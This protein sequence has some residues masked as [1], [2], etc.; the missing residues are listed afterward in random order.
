MISRQRKLLNEII[1]IDWI[2]E[3]RYYCKSHFLLFVFLYFKIKISLVFFTV[4]IAWLAAHAK[5]F[6]KYFYCPILSDKDN[7]YF[8]IKLPLFSISN[9][10]LLFC[11]S[12]RK[13]VSF[14]ACFL[15]KVLSLLIEFY[16]FI[17]F[18]FTWC[19]GTFCSLFLVLKLA[20]I[21]T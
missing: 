16:Y 5:L 10:C 4:F 18:C 21:K 2:K 3:K 8:E 14:S 12:T 7:F 9:V 15:S 19:S 11:F 1:V 13:E 6:E 17:F 20:K